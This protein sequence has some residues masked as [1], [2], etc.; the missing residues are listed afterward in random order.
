MLTTTPTFTKG[1]ILKLEMLEQLRDFPLDVVAIIMQPLSNGI[2]TGLE[3]SIAESTLTIG[4]GML[5]HDGKIHVIPDATEIEYGS[6]EQDTLLKLIIHSQ[7]LTPDFAETHLEF[8]LTPSFE[9][10][11][12][13]VELARFKLKPGAYLRDDYQDLADFMTVYNTVNVAHCNYAGLGGRPSISP[14]I[15]TYFARELMANET[16]NPHDIAMYCTLLNGSVAV[17]RELLEHYIAMRFGMPQASLSNAA[18]HEGLVNI[19]TKVKQERR[20]GTA[21]FTDGRRLI[22]D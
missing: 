21:S 19:I 17:R 16:A 18:I 6:S 20:T 14:A 2:I 5:K 13:E 22:V 1:R 15:T 4:A 11:D 8:Q 3:L 7:N 12:N 9:L 10:E